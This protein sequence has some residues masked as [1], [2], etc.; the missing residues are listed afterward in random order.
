MLS[1]KPQIWPVKDTLKRGKSTDNDHNL[2][3][4]EGG[5]GTS[6]CKISGHFLHAFSGLYPETSGRTDER[7]DGSR[8]VG[9]TNGPMDRWKEGFSGF[10]L[11]DG[12][13]TRR[14]N[15]SGVLRL[16]HNNEDIDY[17][18]DA[19]KTLTQIADILYRTKNKLG[20]KELLNYKYYFR[21]VT[22]ILTLQQ[23]V[24]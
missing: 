12:W 7:T 22:N 19:W 10:G 5:Q 1:S 17:S 3:S 16:G 14:H 20:A 2:I 24:L 18:Y 13:T 21:A 4:L 8:L 6:A 9:W 11:T 23:R 15:A